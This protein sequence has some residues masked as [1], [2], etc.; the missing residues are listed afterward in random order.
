MARREIWS[1]AFYDFANSAFTTSITTVVF[2]Y[3]FVNV[4][5]GAQGARI[6][7]TTIPSASL[8]SYTIA[9]AMGIICL[10]GPVLGAIADFSGTKKRFLFVYCYAGCVATCLL[11]MVLPGDYVLASILFVLGTVG[12]AGGNVFYNALLPELA[13][14]ESVGRVSG[15]GWAVG[16]AGGGLCLALNLL[17]IKR[18]H[19]FGLSDANYWPTR[20]SFVVVS[21]WWALFAVP[22]FLFVRER[23]KKEGRGPRRSYAAIGFGRLAQTFREIRRYRQ[24]ALFLVAFLIYNDAIQTVIVMA[25]PFGSQEIGMS[26]GEL[27]ACFLMIQGVALFGSI[28]FGFLVDR[29]GNK[30]AVGL[31]LVVWLACI[32]VATG[33]QTRAMFWAMSVVIA[34][35]LG[36]SQSASRSMMA[37]FTPREKSAEFFGFYA[38]SGKL[39]SLVGPLVFGIVSHAWHFR[40]AIGVMGAHLLVGMMVLLFVD[41]G[42]GIDAA[43]R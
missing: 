5:V 22:T 8:W 2:S 42:K 31:S 11:C 34:L 16:Y 32:A 37:A 18:P 38:I 21:M 24:L 6:F 33:V 20:I 39:A 7:G 19:W 12:F 13:D 41:E 10:T 25:T 14:E 15:L 30:R 3:Y 27:I 9:F 1:W 28:G 40:G 17:M 4:V 36:G 29:V 26:Q 23:A 43:R 35:V